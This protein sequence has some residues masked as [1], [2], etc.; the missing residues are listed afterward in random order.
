MKYV[1]AATLSMPVTVIPSAAGDIVDVA[2]L[3]ANQPKESA[4]PTGCLVE[5]VP[6]YVVATLVGSIGTVLGTVKMTAVSLP[7][8]MVITS[9][10]WVIGS[11]ASA[12]PTHG[13]LGICDSAGVQRAHTADSLT[14]VA[15]AN[16]SITRALT[17]PYTI[18][19]TGLYW[20]ALSST[21]LTNPTVAGVSTPGGLSS[22]GTGIL[23][24]I[25]G[26]AAQTT[27]GTDGVT[28]Y[29][30]PTAQSAIPYMYLT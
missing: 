7:A 26:S 30:P 4:Q 18:P 14:T 6:R 8:G 3:Y 5:T 1:G 25:S 22:T 11:T 10:T 28:T 19:T 9:I 27:P 12:S 20:I 23:S 2:Y 16:S 24:G 15:A 17:T 29:T 21:A 13:W